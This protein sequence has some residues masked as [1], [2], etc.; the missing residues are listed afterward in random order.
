MKRSVSDVSIGRISNDVLMKLELSHL[1]G[2]KQFKKIVTY[3]EEL[4]AR[5]VP[6]CEYLSLMEMKIDSFVTKSAK[7]FDTK[8]LDTW[9]NQYETIKQQY[10]LSNKVLKAKINDSANRKARN[11]PHRTVRA[12]IDYS[13]LDSQ[14]SLR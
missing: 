6:A 3:A 11:S 5:S 4:K 13:Y 2:R 9:R 10:V 1:L 7:P 14:V 12:K 8:K